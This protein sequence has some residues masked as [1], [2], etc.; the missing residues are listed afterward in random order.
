MSAEMV[1]LCSGLGID[2]EEVKY[3]FYYENSEEELDFS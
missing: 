2:P 1:D 3:D